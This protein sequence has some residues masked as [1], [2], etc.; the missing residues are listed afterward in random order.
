MKKSLKFLA[1][2]CGCLVILSACKK[3][4]KEPEPV[5]PNPIIGIWNMDSMRTK[6]TLNGSLISD[7]SYPR[8]SGKYTNTYNDVDRVI[9]KTPFSF[10]FKYDTLKYKMPVSDTLIHLIRGKNNAVDTVKNTYRYSIVNGKMELYEETVSSNPQQPY[11]TETRQYFR[12]V[13]Q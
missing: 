11:K 6:V 8:D 1:F 7:V 3:E 12:K 2:V 10:N 5:V 4:E 13:G 9:I